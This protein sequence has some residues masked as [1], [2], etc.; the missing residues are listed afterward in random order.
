MKKKLLTLMLASYLTINAG[1]LFD[2]SARAAEN[3]YLFVDAYSSPFIYYNS[4]GKK[5]GFTVGSYG[6]FGNMSHFFEGNFSYSNFELTSSRI[7]QYNAVLS[8][9]NYQLPGFG[10]KAG[11]NLT[12]TSYSGTDQ[13]A[14]LFTGIK[15]YFPF[16]YGTGVSFN[17][18]LDFY[19]SFYRA[20]NNQQPVFQLTPAI[21]LGLGGFYLEA[22]GTYIK[23]PQDSIL[24]NNNMF[25]A[26]AA[27]TYNFNNRF[28]IK[29][30][31]WLGEQAFAVR[32]S[33][34]TVFNVP[35]KHMG[36]YGLSAQYSF[37]DRLIASVSWYNEHYYDISS[38]NQ[39]LLITFPIV[40]K[41]SF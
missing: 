10:L 11:T 3:N 2:T 6:Y 40:L 9:T 37:T 19:T 5:S 22:G 30:S 34:F 35:E 41:Y 7:N 29:A 32:D 1:S 12:A 20:Y 8:Y 14:V 26:E 23:L 28:S 39:S 27:I 25:S 33:G 15:Y 13:A 17:A 21:G 18:G 38:T 31:G 24:E 36:G 4:Q 16:L